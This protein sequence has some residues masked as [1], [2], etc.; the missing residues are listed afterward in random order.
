MSF[1]SLNPLTCSNG[2]FATGTPI[3]HTQGSSDVDCPGLVSSSGNATLV[4]AADAAAS[5]AASAAQARKR[6]TTTITITV[7]LLLLSAAGGVIIYLY[8]RKKTRLTETIDGQDTKPRKFEEV[9]G[10]I[11]IT[12]PIDLPSTPSSRS[13]LAPP[14]SSHFISDVKRPLSSDR[15]EGSLHYPSRFPST[16]PSSP[17][18]HKANEPDALP[19]TEVRRATTAIP[20]PRGG[21]RLPQLPMPSRSASAN[22]RP[23]S[24]NSSGEPDIIIQHRDGGVVQELPPPYRFTRMTRV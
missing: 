8:L 18:T 21:R 6:T 20:L 22:V 13:S 19:V 10:P 2:N 4:Q 23:P 11:S 17:R 1:E 9:S 3:V 24:G 15:E 7:I 12:L 5:A 14:Y 16:R